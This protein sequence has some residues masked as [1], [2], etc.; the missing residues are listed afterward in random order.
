MK[1]ERK[2]T[3]KMALSRRQKN[4]KESK[5]QKEVKEVNNFEHNNRKRKK[6][7]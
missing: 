4:E 7:I 3:E 5:R 6:E 2:R 1:K